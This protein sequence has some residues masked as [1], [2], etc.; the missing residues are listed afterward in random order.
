MKKLPLFIVS[1]VIALIIWVGVSLSYEYYYTLSL[2]LKITNL[3]NEFAVAEE[4]PER[5]TIKL[6]ARGWKLAALLAS[7]NN[8]FLIDARKDTGKITLKVANAVDENSWLTSDIQVLEYQPSVINLKLERLIWKS[9][10]VLPEIENSFKSGYGLAGKIMIQ[11]DSVT[12]A[13]AKSYIERLRYLTTEK[14]VFENL[15]SQ[16]TESIPVEYPKHISV[17]PQ[18]VSVTIDAQKIVDKEFQDIPVAI[19]DVPGDRQVL[20]IPD[21]ITV[22]VEGGVSLLGSMDPANIKAE[23]HYKDIIAD[24]L[25]FVFPKITVPQYLR[26]VSQKPE[27]LRYILKKF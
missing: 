26:V 15:S 22:G 4:L 8:E 1:F 20:I 21:K 18:S 17:F 10:P 14:Y 27:R 24:S 5:M 12:V 13:G 19:L 7:G 9:V 2:P 16:T 6:K 23:L 3:G 25:G 11:P